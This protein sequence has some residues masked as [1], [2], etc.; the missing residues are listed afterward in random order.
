MLTIQRRF[1]LS[2]REGFEEELAK[3]LDEFGVDFMNVNYHSTKLGDKEVIRAHFEGCSVLG[4]RFDGLIER[5][6]KMSV[7]AGVVIVY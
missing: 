2:I 7:S 5:L 3:I 4:N 6:D 1:K